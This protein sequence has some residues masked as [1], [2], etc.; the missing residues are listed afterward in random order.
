MPPL[1]ED[2]LKGQ[3]KLLA[4][5]N[6]K[7]ADRYERQSQGEVQKGDSWKGH[8]KLLACGGRQ[9]GEHSKSE[10]QREGYTGRRELER[11][12]EVVGLWREEKG[13]RLGRGFRTGMPAKRAEERRGAGEGWSGWGRGASAVAVGNNTNNQLAARTCL[14]CGPR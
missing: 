1:G 4:C 13:R 5:A 8:R 10:R 12:Q 3:R 2:S 9:G 7:Q 6:E 14:G 11:P